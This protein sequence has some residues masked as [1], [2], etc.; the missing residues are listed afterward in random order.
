V[1]A[2]R[3]AARR[4]QCV[5]NLKQQALACQTYHQT[6]NALPAARADDGPTWCVYLLPYLEQ[7]AQYEA[8]NFVLAWPSQLNLAVKISPTAFICPARRTAMLS[9]QGDGSGGIGDWPGFPGAYTPHTAHNPGPVGDYAACIGSIA[10][11]IP[12]GDAQVPNQ[13]QNGAFQHVRQPGE[14][15]NV[16]LPPGWRPPPSK[17]GLNDILDGT[18]NTLFFGEKHVHELNYGRLNGPNWS[19]TQNCLDNCMY[20][21]DNG[22][23]AG[24]AAGRT[25]LLARGKEPCSNTTPRFGSFHP[26]G[27]NFALGDASVRTL[28]F[29]V[30]G[31]VLEKL[32][33]RKGG[34]PTDAF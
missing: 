21:G 18:T 31:T 34:E 12:P 30:S 7:E 25:I 16:Q 6:F 13:R 23:T 14:L 3:E 4:T 1:Q 27:V 17:L 24:R 2:A 9:T 19:G 10:E 20:N 8:F 11:D 32:A 29:S 5:N 26:A 15:T 22:M 33:T 28:S